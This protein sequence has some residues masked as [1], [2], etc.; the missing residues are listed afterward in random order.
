MH[1][2]IT[3]FTLGFKTA[4][5]RKGSIDHNTCSEVRANWPPDF[6]CLCLLVVIKTEHLVILLADSFVR[7]DAPKMPR[8]GV[9]DSVFIW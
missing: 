2:T 8:A 9:T 6:P 5:F 4:D 1:K 7:M 3:F